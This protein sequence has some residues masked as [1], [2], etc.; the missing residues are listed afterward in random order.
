MFSP[1]SLHPA[2][3][4]TAPPNPGCLTRVMLRGVR[5]QSEVTGVHCGSAVRGLAQVANFL[6]HSLTQG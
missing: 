4:F 3:H 1:P 5:E 6:T 2:L